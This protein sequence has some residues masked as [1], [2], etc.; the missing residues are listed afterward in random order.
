MNLNTPLIQPDR[1]PDL[2]AAIMRRLIQLL[3]FILIQAAILFLASGRLDWAMAW[4]YLGVYA[5]LIVVNAIVLL[6]RDPELIAERG[7]IQRNVKS[8]DKVFSVFY[9]LSSLGLLVVAGLDNRWGWSPQM[10][11]TAQL[12][13]LALY[14]LG[15]ALVS[16]AMASNRF[17][18]TVVRIQTDRGHTVATGGPYRFVRHPGYVGMIVSALGTTIL[19]GSLW[20]FIPT[21]LLI[22][23]VVARTA[24]EDK[25]LQ[26]ELGGYKEYAG[27]VRY[28]LLPGV[29]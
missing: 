5:G 16:W 21:G 17:F 19:L 24:L 13:G 22:G 27:R 28:R 1:K 25:T 2:T 3:V 29:W 23:L 8:W 20:A 7:Q 12:S 14:V 9:V 18:S 6:P 4:V 10:N 26:A 15:F 11:L